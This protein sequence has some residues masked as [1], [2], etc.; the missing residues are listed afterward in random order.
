MGLVGGVRLVA[1]GGFGG[2]EGDHHPLGGEPFDVLQQRLEEAVGHA[3]GNP[4]LGAQPA[5]AALGEGIETAEGQGM[6]IH[7]Q[8][9]GVGALS[10]CCALEAALPC[11]MGPLRSF[12][13]SQRR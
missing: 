2:V 11:G 1:E 3:G 4:R 10:R 9:Q 12:N 8:Q 7:Q 13:L 5:V 6:A